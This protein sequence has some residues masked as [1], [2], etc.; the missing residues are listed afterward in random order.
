MAPEPAPV[1]SGTPELELLLELV[2]ELPLELLELPPVLVGGTST[3]HPVQ[4]PEIITPA[5]TI[6]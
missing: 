5:A 2:L 6:H 4:T 3:T 1:Q